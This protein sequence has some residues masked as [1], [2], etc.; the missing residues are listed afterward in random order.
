MLS[1]CEKWNKRTHLQKATGENNSAPK[2]MP[3]LKVILYLFNVMFR[4]GYLF[5]KLNITVF[6][7]GNEDS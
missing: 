6:Y 4:V 3:A 7:K 1:T 5:K 2:T